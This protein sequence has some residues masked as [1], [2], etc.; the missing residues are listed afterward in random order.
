VADTLELAYFDT[1]ALVKRYV[2]EAGS[3]YLRTLLRR[4]DVISS[5]VIPVELCSALRRRREEGRLSDTILT[6][7]LHRLRTD[8]ATWRLVPVADE[9]LALARERVLEHPLRSLDAI[10]VASAESMR[11]AGLVLP[12]ITADVRQAGAARTLGL[13]VIDAVSGSSA[14]S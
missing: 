3:V 2:V 7:M 12:F 11:R 1:S 8:L 9:V 10:H 14:R 6:R 13:H 4:Y 5:A